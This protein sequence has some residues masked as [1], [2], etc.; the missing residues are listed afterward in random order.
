MDE[1][2]VFYQALSG[3][4]FTL[5][6]LW[7]GVIQFAHG[8]WRSDPRRHRATLHIALHF[9]LPGT[10]ALGSL[11]SGDADGG[12]LWRVAFV[13]GGVIGCAES[14]AF[15]RFPSGVPGLGVSALRLLDPLLYAL[16]VVVA[17]VPGPVGVL[18]PLQMEGVLTGLLFLTGLCYVWLAFAERERVGPRA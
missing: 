10:M 7:F 4:S 16:V 11:L 14:V 17:F 9:F 13:L 15:L 5:L 6:G 8:G 3:V 2:T 18:T 12:L 1:A